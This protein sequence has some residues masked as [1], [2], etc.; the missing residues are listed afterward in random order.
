MT[1]PV[2]I[3]LSLKDLAQTGGV[4]G[5]LYAISTCGSILSTFLTGFVLIASFGTREIVLGVG[6][7]LILL[8]VTFG[9]LLTGNRP[10]ALATTTSLGLLAVAIL[11]IGQRMQALQSGCTK[12]TNYYCIRV[13][14]T[15]LDGRNLEQ[16]I[17]DHLIHSYNDPN[18][19][20]YVHYGY[21]KVYAEMMNYL[22]NP[23]L[24][25]LQLGGGGYTMP[26]YVET[27]FP[28]AQD[29]VIEIDPGVTQIAYQYMGLSPNTRVVTVNT[30][31][32]VGLQE[33]DP[34]R[35]FDLI[36]GDAF[37]DLSVPYHLTT[38][39]FDRDLRQHLAPTGFFLANIIDKM[40]GGHF[41]P[42]IVRT[43][44]TVFPHVYVLSEVNS[45]NTADQ[46]T[47]VVAASQQPLDVTRLQQQTKGLGP[48]GQVLTQVMPDDQMTAWLQAAHP[49]VL[50]DNYV[51]TDNL[52][53]PL[54]LERN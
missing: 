6:I 22:D 34:N 13:I 2:V 23:T 43:L 27:I 51:P 54:F 37:N 8:A 42:A 39:E 14:A 29:E 4:V 12:E 25:V 31:A 1:T 33:M 48:N 18:D 49:V 16:L 26:R 21:E 20:T 46:N 5:R 9:G 52:L 45:F 38:Q 50:T 10:A 7:L 40:Q 32:R 47:Y 19:P 3:K 11:T 53:A 41:I 36:L 15:Q 28:Q 30:D 44:Q 17:L 35:E 24:R